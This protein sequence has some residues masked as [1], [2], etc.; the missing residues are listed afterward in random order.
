M[1]NNISSAAAWLDSH[2]TGGTQI[3]RNLPEFFHTRLPEI[4]HKSGKKQRINGGWCTVL[5]GWEY[6]QE[7]PKVCVPLQSG[8][9]KYTALDLK[10]TD[11]ERWIALYRYLN[12][13]QTWTTKLT[14]W[15][16]SFYSS[17]YLL[18]QKL[19]LAAKNPPHLPE[20]CVTSVGSDSS[21]ITKRRSKALSWRITLRLWICLIRF[22]FYYL[23]M[24]FNHSWRP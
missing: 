9:S 6:R 10:W 19:T 5:L 16:G 24:F 22:D 15:R 20:F 7:Y 14:G 12:E 4:A 2:S 8:K 11:A 3:P 18:G 13:V 17:M 1:A 21:T 23:K